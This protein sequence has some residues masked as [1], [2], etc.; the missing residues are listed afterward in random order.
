VL[1]EGVAGGDERLFVSHIVLCELVW[2]L[3]GA[4][5]RP[6]DDVLAALEGLIS[7]AQLFVEDAE[8]AHR[9]LE[10]YRRGKADFADYV[11]AERAWTAGC[12]QVATFDG[13]L[14]GEEGFFA[15]SA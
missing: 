3:R 12:S 10:R 5:G 11:I 6:K 8:L 1:L 4:Y 2:V 14:L 7:S 13:K 15:P 9:A